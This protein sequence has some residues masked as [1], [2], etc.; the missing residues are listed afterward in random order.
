[1]KNSQVVD[2]S[3]ETNIARFHVIHDL[4]AIFVHHNVI[5]SDFNICNAG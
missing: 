4:L 2:F 3:Y 5:Y 1:M